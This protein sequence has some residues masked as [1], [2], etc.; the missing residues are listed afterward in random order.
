MTQFDYLFDGNKEQ[1][2]YFVP[3][4]EICG[5]YRLNQDLNKSAS[6]NDKKLN[7]SD[8]AIPCGLFLAM[9]PQGEITIT[10]NNNSNIQLD[11]SNLVYFPYEV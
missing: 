1:G 8:Y 10:L 11:Q 2:D 4:S 3:N 9:F 7:P 6:I 5:K